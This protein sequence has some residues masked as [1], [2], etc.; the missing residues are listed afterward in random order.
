MGAEQAVLRLEEGKMYKTADAVVFERGHLV[1]KLEKSGDSAPMCFLNQVPGGHRFSGGEWRAVFSPCQC[2]GGPCGCCQGAGAAEAQ[3]HIEWINR[4]DDWART[5]GAHVELRGRT[6][7][8]VR[9]EEEE[10]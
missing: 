9:D 6:I 3:A 10:I 8:I 1:S 4:L 5:K 2:D 7:C